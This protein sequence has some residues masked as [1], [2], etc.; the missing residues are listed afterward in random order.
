MFLPRSF[1]ISPATMRVESD[2]ATGERWGGIRQLHWLV[3]DRPIRPLLMPTEVG[4]DAEG[5]R[6]QDGMT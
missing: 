6:R 4:K 2:G 3:A 1:L 5:E